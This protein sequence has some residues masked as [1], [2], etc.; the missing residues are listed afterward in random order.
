MLLTKY[1]SFFLRF[2]RVFSMLLTIRTYYQHR[3]PRLRPSTCLNN[4]SK[5]TPS[6]EYTLLMHRIRTMHMIYWTRSRLLCSPR[7]LSVI[8][9]INPSKRHRPSAF[10]RDIL[11]TRFTLLSG[12]LMMT[13]TPESW[14]GLP[15]DSSRD[16]L[17]LGWHK[18][19]SA[20]HLHTWKFLELARWASPQS[21]DSSHSLWVIITWWP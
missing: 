4:R 19:M 10:L 6:Q 9:L 21:A 5:V 2:H 13:W 15:N 8:R 11:Y 12:P 7:V 18:P 16:E 1:F 14:N 17:S 3:S 20:Q